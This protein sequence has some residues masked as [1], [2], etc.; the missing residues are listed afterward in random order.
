METAYQE[1]ILVIDG[2]P[3][4]GRATLAQRLATHYNALFMD[5]NLLICALVIEAIVQKVHLHDTNQLMKL[6]DN[7][8]V[9]IRNNHVYLFG[10]DIT[11]DIQKPEIAQLASI[12]K[13][14][15]AI[16]EALYTTYKDLW[17]SNPKSIAIGH[18]MGSHVF[19]LAE[20]K[21]FLTADIYTRAKRRDES[22]FSI[23]MKDRKFPSFA[24]DDAL[25]LDT[26]NMAPD[27]VFSFVVGYADSLRAA[28]LGT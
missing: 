3:G 4:S 16:H 8:D 26:T 17:I 21:I 6:A 20:F 10:Y 14:I 25:C 18:N 9:S 15:P 2:L 27:D 28:H 5:T 19:P 24:P 22:I 11:E 23:S 1:D 12:L 7:L 13:N